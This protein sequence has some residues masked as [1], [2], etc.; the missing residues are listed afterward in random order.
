LGTNADTIVLGAGITPADVTLTRWYDDLVIS[1]NGTDDRLTVSG[2]FYNDGTSVYAVEAIRFAD[3][4]SWSI[5]DVK[6]RAIASTAG[7]DGL[8]GYATN[9]ALS[10]G[11]GNDTL[12][13]MAGTDTL[14]G[15][16][17]RDTLDGGDGS[18][19]LV[20]GAGND[21]L[22]GGS[23]NDTLDGGL[24]NDSLSGGS[25]SD[26]LDGGVGNDTL[27][28]GEGADTYVFS[29]GSGQD[30]INNSDGDA[31]G[32]NAD[33]IV[34]GAGITPADVTLTRSYDTLI[35]SLN[36]TDDRLSVSSYFTNDGTSAY[37]VE[38]IRFA[39]GTS[40]SIADVKARAIAS[41]TGDDGLTGYATNDALS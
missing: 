35:I 16:D 8:T 9:D 23:G 40:W 29:L 17:G 36:G 10:G 38:A 41:T 27:Y 2:Y 1:I 24:G 3:G 11:D 25:G 26:T 28:G 12:S 14:D 6:A 31:L 15:G 37:A 34:L 22:T 18:D 13:G 33:T 30:T 7:D 20:G 4:T 19:T 21:S 39:D 32:T 5:A